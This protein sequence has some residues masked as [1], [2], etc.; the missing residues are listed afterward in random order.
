MKKPLTR[1]FFEE[2]GRMGGEKCGPSK[3]RG[4]SDYYRKLN[5][6]SR[7]ARRKRLEKERKI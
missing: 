1:E 3:R 2:M 4:D 5:S 7:E 6:A